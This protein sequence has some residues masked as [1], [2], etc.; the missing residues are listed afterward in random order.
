MTSKLK[1]ER[2]WAGEQKTDISCYNP[3]VHRPLEEKRLGLLG[4]E[5][6]QRVHMI[7]NSPV[8]LQRSVTAY[9]DLWHWAKWMPNLL[10]CTG[11]ELT[12]NLWDLNGSSPVGV[13]A[14]RVPVTNG[15]VTTS[16]SQGVE[17]VHTSI[18]GYFP[19]SSCKVHRDKLRH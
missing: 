7:K 6:G 3:Q 17:Q 5:P 11:P 14:Y 2:E 12:L 8:L 18:C 4:E 13:E 15:V 10:C 9:K 19:A 16:V 1:T